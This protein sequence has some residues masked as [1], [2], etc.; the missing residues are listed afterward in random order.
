[1][2][3]NVM[4]TGLVLWIGRFIEVII[5][6]FLFVLI[7]LVFVLLTFRLNFLRIGILLFLLVIWTLFR[8]LIKPRIC[9]F[10]KICIYMNV[11]SF[12]G[13]SLNITQRAWKI[14]TCGTKS[15]T[16]ITN[17]ALSRNFGQPDASLM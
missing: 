4:A 17:P 11:G 2:Y 9:L 7:I 5:I 14:D 15:K 16:N 3:P 6:K 8:I 13:S 10:P 12:H 1:M